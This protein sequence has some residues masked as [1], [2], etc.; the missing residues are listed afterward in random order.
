MTVPSCDR[1]LYGL[2]TLSFRRERL[3]LSLNLNI[4]LFRCTLCIR[5]QRLHSCANSRSSSADHL[6]LCH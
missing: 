3:S 1:A 2:D 6:L 4:S 5:L